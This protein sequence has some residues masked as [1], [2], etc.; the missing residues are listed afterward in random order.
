[1]LFLI[2]IRVCKITIY[3]SFC[4]IC[5]FFSYKYFIHNICYLANNNLLFNYLHSNIFIH[6]KSKKI[7]FFYCFW[8]KKYVLQLFF[9]FLASQF[10]Y[11]F[12]HFFYSF[13]SILFAFVIYD[14]KIGSVSFIF[15]VHLVIHPSFHGFVGGIVSL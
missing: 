6:N 5:L 13:V 11:F 2:L 10:Q 14:Y 7:F 12:V 8:R 1:M 9:L 15:V 3:F 4:K